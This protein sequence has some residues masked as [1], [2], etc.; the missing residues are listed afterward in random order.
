MEWSWGLRDLNGKVVAV[1]DDDDAP[2]PRY[3]AEERKSGIAG[4][5]VLSIYLY[6]DG[7]VKEIRVIRSLSPT[8]DKMTI[9]TVRKMKFRRLEADSAEPEDLRLQFT[10]RATCNPRF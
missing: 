10:F 8:L 2:P 1:A 7:R 4:K 6:S 9:D 5:L 3:L